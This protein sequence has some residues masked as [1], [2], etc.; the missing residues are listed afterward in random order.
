MRNVFV[1]LIGAM[2][3]F[4]SG[5]GK[6]KTTAPNEQQPPP[7]TRYS[8]TTLNDNGQ[9][10]SNFAAY[11][12]VHVSLGSL[13][14][15]TLYAIYVK[16][17][18]GTI[19]ARYRLRTNRNGDLPP[20]AVLY[21]PEPG[22]YTIDIPEAG[23]VIPVT[24]SEPTTPYVRTVDAA[25]RFTNNYSTGEPA[26]IIGR[27]FPPRTTVHIYVVENRYNWQYGTYLYDYTES[28]EEV[29]TDSTG[30]IPQTV[31]WQNPVNDQ[32]TA[33]DIVV[34]MNNNGLYDAGDVLNANLGM[35]FVVQTPPGAKRNIN[36][37]IVERL[38]CDIN[39]VY[40]DVFTVNEEVYAYLNPQAKMRDLGGDRRVTWYILQHKDEWNNGD[41]LAQSDSVI[42]DCVQYGCTN[43]GRRLLVNGG[44]LRPGK[45]DI[46]IDV[47]NNAKYDKGTDILDGYSG[48]GNWVGFTVIGQPETRKWTVLVY[49]DGEGGL[50]GTRSRYATEIAN[51]MDNSMYAA[52]LFDGDN[53]AGYTDCKR[54]ICKPGQVEE[55]FDFGELNMG[56]PLTLHDFLT[57]G[58]ASF[59]AEHYLIVISNHGGSWFKED[60]PVPNELWY[61]GG[62][63]V[64]YDGVDGLNMYE[65]ESV[66]KD[67]YRL[68]GG[69]L[70]IVWYQACLMGA[71]EVASISKNYFDYMVAH[72]TV[73]YGSE[74]NN[75]FP[76]VIRA[77]R[78]GIS[79]QTLAETI[80]TAETKPQR[81]FCAAYDLSKYNDLE[82]KIASFVNAVLNGPV[83][84]DSFKAD[85][86]DALVN[87]RGLT[88][89]PNNVEDPGMPYN[90]NRDMFDFF[91]RVA[92]NDSSNIPS[93]VRNAANEVTQ[94]I[95]Q[96]VIR[97][98]GASGMPAGLHG[99]AIWLPRA[100][101]LFVNYAAEYSGFDF[102]TRTRWP[103]FLSHLYGIAYRIELTWGS[104][105]RD[106]D[107]H[108]FD[109][110]EPPRHVYY[111]CK[112][113]IPGA[114]LDLD[115]V[116]G[117]GPENIHIAFLTP[118]PRGHYEYWVYLFAGQDTIGELSTVKVFL[119]GNA[120]PSRIYYRYWTDGERWWHVFNIDD[121]TGAIIDVDAVGGPAPSFRFRMPPKY[122][123]EAM[124]KAHK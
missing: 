17:H 30:A 84:V 74:N 48:E 52:V 7:P 53:D 45:Y 26:R 51:N 86:Y 80:V 81:S 92:N 78:G 54:Y 24:V 50:S 123:N 55:D 16:D 118:G 76:N 82:N 41:T 6:K 21:D 101:S 59:P 120:N 15:N 64:C 10:D 89:D 100:E 93:S 23:V 12:N 97:S 9:P 111:A 108:L 98:E 40:R 5:C 114:Y 67:L 22:N 46:I 11:E 115:D 20:S 70:D 36:G 122:N 91:E 85:L 105:P 32:H 19:I 83:S 73:R 4:F 61:D 25:G 13:S 90:M 94:S 47:N 37:H 96:F 124:K 88:A 119:G 66:Y 113:C 71:V 107:S 116:T 87:S 65:L 38:S 31:I 28:V 3:L 1:V 72:E 34:D 49:A 110:Q 102:A 57:W 79:P 44:N 95:R 77:M 68:V 121:R 35:A 112:N 2:V 117:Y 56:H 14:P 43:I 8:T 29:V 63:A 75:K 104:E 39:F 103:D 109:S 99:V 69:K 33:F 42:I 106:L 58:I 27:N 62:K 18:T 60:H